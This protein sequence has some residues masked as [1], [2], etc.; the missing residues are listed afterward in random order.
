[1]AVTDAELVNRVLAGSEHAFEALVHRYERPVFTVIVRVVRD[2]SRAEELAQDTFLKAFRRLETY[3]PRRKFSSWVLAIAHNTAIDDLRRGGGKTVS[4][5]D[6]ADRGE[7]VIDVA[8]DGP[9]DKAERAELARTLARAID[10]LSPEYR[11]LV[12]LR[13]ENDLDYDE[14][15]EITGLPMGTVKSY[16]HRARRALGERLRAAG[17]GMPRQGT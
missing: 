10:Q 14:I 13:Y 9:G 17:W 2:P 7:G 1:M 5:E 4:F 6:L 3:D 11:A 8:S 12:G 16:L 15:V